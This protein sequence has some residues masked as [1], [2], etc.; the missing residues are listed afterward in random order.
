VINAEGEKNIDMMDECDANLQSWFGWIYPISAN[1]KIEPKH[2]QSQ[3]RLNEIL[4]DE[5]GKLNSVLIEGITRTYAPRVAGETVSQY[6]DVKTKKF[7]LTYYI[8]KNCGETTIFVS[9]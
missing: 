8:C 2:K 1:G 7:I 6:Y 3:H 5:N 9:E 4:Y